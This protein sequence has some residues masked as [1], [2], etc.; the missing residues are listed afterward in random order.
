MRRSLGLAPKAIRCAVCWPRIT[1]MPGNCSTK[2]S[3]ILSHRVCADF[4][5]EPL[6]R[7][8]HHLRVELLA[9]ARHQHVT[10]LVDQAHRVK[11]PGMNRPLRMLLHVA[12]RVHAV[13]ELAA[14]GKI[15][16]NNIPRIGK[17]RLR[18][19][20]PLTRIPGYMEFH[21]E[22]I[23]LP[24]SFIHCHPERSA[25]KS[26]DLLLLFARVPR[27]RRSLFFA[28]RV[29]FNVEIKAKS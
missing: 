27:P 14:G 6:Q 29:G 18:E 10:G 12:N 9:I 23:E 20:V 4:A 22:K 19:L 28:A 8:G 5:G 26:K 13:R 15:G 24:S 17:Q 7:A 3:S 1:E 11:L 25:A 21:H 16:E 2:A